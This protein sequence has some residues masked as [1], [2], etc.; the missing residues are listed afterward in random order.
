MVLGLR[1]VGWASS[2]HIG[3]FLAVFALEGNVPRNS[4]DLRPER[5]LMSSGFV[6]VP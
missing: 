3:N 2:F 4:D 6:P 5:S 1:A